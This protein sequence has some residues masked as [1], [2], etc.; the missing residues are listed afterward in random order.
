MT[1][2][3]AKSF[4]PEKNPGSVELMFRSIA[5]LGRSTVEVAGQF[6]PLQNGPALPASMLRK[7]CGLNSKRVARFDR[8]VLEQTIIT[9]AQWDRIFPTIT[10]H[11]EVEVGL[12]VLQDPW[13]VA[14][15]LDW[16]EESQLRMLPDREGFPRI[17]LVLGEFCQNFWQHSQVVSNLKRLRAAKVGM[18]IN[19]LP[20]R[21]DASDLVV[22]LRQNCTWEYLKIHP[23]FTR[24]VVAGHIE[25]LSELEEY[26]DWTEEIGSRLVMTGVRTPEELMTIDR[27]VRNIGRGNAVAAYQGPLSGRSCSIA[28]HTYKLAEMQA[29]RQLPLFKRK[30]VDYGLSTK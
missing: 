15:I 17:V 19:Y 16:L 25:A 4:L 10:V 29:I 30:G 27:Q 23:R 21:S 1:K 11:A 6:S 7:L 5:R 26:L 18:V 3:L 20:Y 28:G 2:S 24:S 14:C 12:G 8:S 22:W 13:S 9:L